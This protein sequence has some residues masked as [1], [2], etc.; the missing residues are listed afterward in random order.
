[1]V[2]EENHAGEQRR[3]NEHDQDRHPA[4]HRGPRPAQ[5]PPPAGACAARRSRRS[6]S[7]APRS[8]PSSRTWETMQALSHC[9]VVATIST[10][11]AA[12]DVSVPPIETLTNST[13]SARYLSRSGM[14]GAKIVRRQHQGGDGHRRRLGDQR[15]EQRDRGQA[16]QAVATAPRHRQHAGEPIDGAD[17]RHQDRPRGG[18][19]H[20]HED[21]QR[22]GVVARL[23]IGERL[24]AAGHRH[25]REDQHDGPEA[26]HDL[27]LAEQVE[28]PGMPRDSGA[29][30]ARAAW[31]RRCGSGRERRCRG[32][33]APG[34]DQAPTPSA[35]RA[36]PA[37]PTRPAAGR[38]R[39]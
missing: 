25:H 17:D 8:P 21:E 29:T 1:M 11:G 4:F 39:R 23:R 26:E 9:Q 6:R 10:G 20:H 15:S 34:R 33:R 28:Q 7:P 5:A 35:R 16:S 19:D 38:R 27:D 3:V 24:R 14:C 31:R 12:Y 32:R 18:H 37:S 2:N 22:L 36:V 13:P 30:A